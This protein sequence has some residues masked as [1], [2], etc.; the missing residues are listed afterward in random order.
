MKPKLVGVVQD[1]SYAGQRYWLVRY[2]PFPRW[3]WVHLFDGI[4]SDAE[5]EVRVECLEAE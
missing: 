2:S 1:G 3:W 5:R 4:W